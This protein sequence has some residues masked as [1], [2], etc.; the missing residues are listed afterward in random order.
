MA[1]RATL[2]LTRIQYTLK[3]PRNDMTART[4][5]QEGKAERGLS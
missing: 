3:N 5:R 1:T 4:S 2:R